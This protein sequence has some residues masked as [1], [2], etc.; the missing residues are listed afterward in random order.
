MNRVAISNP[1]GNPQRAIRLDH[2]D[3]DDVPVGEDGEIDRLVEGLQEVEH[4]GLRKITEP[5]QVLVGFRQGAKTT[6]N[7]I[8]I[9]LSVVVNERGSGERLQISKDRRLG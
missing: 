9:P 6:T 1:C 2:V 4:L 3:V 7:T 8:S 5:L